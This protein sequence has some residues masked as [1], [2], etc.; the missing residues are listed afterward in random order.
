MLEEISTQLDKDQP[1]WYIDWAIGS[2][3][4][5]YARDTVQAKTRMGAEVMIVEATRRL[6][7]RVAS[8]LFHRILNASL[9][10]GVIAEPDAGAD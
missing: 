7:N 9:S 10:A 3:L 2:E 8:R 1:N 5:Q 4:E 6:K